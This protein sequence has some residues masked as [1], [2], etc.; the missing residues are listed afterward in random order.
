MSPD[1]N[2]IGFQ[3]VTLGLVSFRTLLN[4][5]G[6][7]ILFWIIRAIYRLFLHPLSQYPGP[8]LAAVSKPW[9]VGLILRCKLSNLSDLGT[10]F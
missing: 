8:R 3:Q 4:I 2:W 5:G 9:Y 1:I 6:L 10:F 7:Y